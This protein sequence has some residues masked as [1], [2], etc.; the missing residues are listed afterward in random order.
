[1]YGTIARMRLKPG[2]E[3]EFKALGQS[4]DEV[5]IPGHLG[6]FIYRMDNDSNEYFMAVI[7]DSKE[8]YH[9]NANSP[10]QDAR[11]QE[12]AALL[13]SE[14]EWHDGEIVHSH[15]RGQ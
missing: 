12:M 4:E 2:K 7:F 14:P 8:S 10:D 6:E 13:E 15:Y 3:E 11:Y 9:A 5:G 1:M